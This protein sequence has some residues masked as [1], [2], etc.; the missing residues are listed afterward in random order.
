VPWSLLRTPAFRALW[1]GRLF[2]WVGSG[3]APLAIVFAA[4]DLGADAVDLGL[5][6]AAR[7]VPNIALVLVGG[8]LADRFSKR[9]V[10]MASSWRSSGTVCPPSRRSAR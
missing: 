8:A 7:S 2:S 10:A 6:V 1:V 9:T 4:I 5:V 3:F